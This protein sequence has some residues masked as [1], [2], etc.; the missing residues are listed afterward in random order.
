M[1][2][3]LEIANDLETMNLDLILLDNTSSHKEMRNILPLITLKLYHFAKF[4]ILHNVPVATEFLFQIFEDF[5]VT[6][7]FPQSLNSRQAFL[8]IP[9][10]Y[11]N[12]NILLG[13][14]CTGVLSLSKWIESR[15][16]LDVDINH[17]NSLKRTSHAPKLK[18]GKLI[19]RE[20]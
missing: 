2:Q 7:F 20:L 10:L 18:L 15:W 4:L 5:F 8:S 12:M 3:Q 13:S 14:R 17:V 1:L 6:G 16:D 19:T 11:T 9:L